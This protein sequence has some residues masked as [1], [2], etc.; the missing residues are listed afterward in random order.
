M[1]F[2]RRKIN[3]KTE[4]KKNLK[5][6]SMKVLH[7]NGTYRHLRFSDGSSSTYWYEVITWPGHLAI[8]GDMGAWTFSRVPDM[9]DFFRCARGDISPQYWAEKLTAQSCYEGPAEKFCIDTFKA[10][11]KECL[12]DVLPM[13]RR[14]AIWDDVLSE[15]SEEAEPYARRAIYEYESECGFTFQDAWE[16]RGKKWSY[17]YLWCCYAIV[18]AI[19]QFDKLKN[20][21]TPKP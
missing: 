8:T 4:I 15:L 7:D 2:K 13:K 20:E 16:I 1:T 10:Q 17:H 3:P 12:R 5:N 21:G 9:F 14:R 18:Y 19:T 6:H 11:L